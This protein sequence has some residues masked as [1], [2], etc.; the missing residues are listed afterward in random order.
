MA[1]EIG[2]SADIV[3]VARLCTSYTHVTKTY[4]LVVCRP[5]GSVPTPKLLVR[6]GDICAFALVWCSTGAAAVAAGCSETA[7]KVHSSATALLVS[8]SSC[9]STLHCRAA[10]RFAKPGCNIAK[11]ITLHCRAVWTSYLSVSARVSAEASYGFFT[12]SANDCSSAAL[13]CNITI[14]SQR[15][16]HKQ[17]VSR[18][19]AQ[20]Y[21][22]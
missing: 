16:H 3:C 8:C 18:G 4:M 10:T 5:R 15:M 17:A 14:E 6:G 9:C 19:M 1:T 11:H 22:I 20:G 13:V 21:L 7:T 12:V 2:W